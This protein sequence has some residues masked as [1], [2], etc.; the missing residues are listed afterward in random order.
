M[1]CSIETAYACSW[2]VW[3]LHVLIQTLLISELKSCHQPCS[4]WGVQ[5]PL[6]PDNKDQLWQ[7]QDK[8]KYS[9]MNGQ[10]GCIS[11]LQQFLFHENLRQNL[12]SYC[13]LTQNEW[14][15]STSKSSF[16]SEESLQW[17]PYLSPNEGARGL[18]A[19]RPCIC[20]RCKL[21]RAI[22]LN[23]LPHD[24]HDV[25]PRCV[26]LWEYQLWRWWYD[27]LQLSHLYFPLFFCHDIQDAG[28]FG[29]IKNNHTMH[30]H[31]VIAEIQ[32]HDY[33]M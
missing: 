30:S 4:N 6:F 26:C 31:C 29:P 12:Y 2:A 25:R 24:L 17:Q 11:V 7:H 1:F 15:I 32:E 21:S 23:I 14:N 28:D 19:W 3:V 9:T 22:R 18:T 10:E 5:N 13:C 16:F 20:N 8:S 27:A 33:I